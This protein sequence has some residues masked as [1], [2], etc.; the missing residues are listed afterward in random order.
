MAR[1][2]PATHDLFRRMAKIETEGIAI[3]QRWREE[4]NHVISRTGS[5]AQKGAED[6][7]NELIIFTERTI[8]Q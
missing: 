1:A 8:W 2:L 6:V 4:V 3:V 5:V 7:L